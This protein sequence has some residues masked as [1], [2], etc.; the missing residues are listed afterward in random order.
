[1]F[2]FLFVQGE[3]YLRGFPGTVRHYGVHGPSGSYRP[4]RQGAQDDSHQV[5]VQE[6][7]NAIFN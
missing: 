5:A 4:D 6:Q 2:H 3:G 1:M 7:V